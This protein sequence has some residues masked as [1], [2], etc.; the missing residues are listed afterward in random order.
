MSKK[1]LI[2]CYYWPPA[3]GPGVQRWLKF[4]KYLPQFNIDPIV[5]V[6]K[7]PSYP[8]LDETLLAEVPEGITIL[9]QPIKEPYRFA[10]ALSRKQTQT[11]SAGIVPKDGKQSVLQQFMLYIRGNFFV[12]DARVQWV[13]PSVTFLKEYIAKND[14]KTVITTG[15]PHSLH[16]IGLAL[17]KSYLGNPNFCWLTDFRDP[18]T[19]IGYHDKLKMTSKT[20]AKHKKLEKEV[21]EAADHI[22]VTSPGTK[23]E[24]AAI[25]SKPISVITNGFDDIDPDLEGI[26]RDVRFTIAHIGSLLSDRNPKVLWKALGDLLNENAAFK[27]HFCLQ[28]VG[29]ISQDVVDSI[30]DAGLKEHLE[31]LGYVAH[32]KALRLQ[33][34]AAVLL[35]VEIDSQQTKAIIPG[36]LFE[37]M[38]TNKPILA[39]GPEGADIALVIKE[40]GIGDF[41]GNGNYDH[42]KNLILGYL[43][44]FTSSKKT[45]NKRVIGQYHRKALTGQLAQVLNKF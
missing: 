40:T 20:Q 6:P 38:A 45:T 9:K 5:Y 11:I 35:L 42:I 7:N 27:E 1:V 43:D 36:K 17:R 32:Q 24:F 41:V 25:T 26:K 31:I 22:L 8:L 44:D 14:I 34:K 30:Y 13:K 3:G 10:S 23:K 29:K 19:T 4:V 16:L 28:L 18:W 2:V 39:I 33:R 12:P 15:P 21:L 37:Y